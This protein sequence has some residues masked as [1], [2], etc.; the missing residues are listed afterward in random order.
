MCLCK[1][2]FYM[3]YF[4]EIWNLN[5]LTTPRDCHAVALNFDIG[6]CH[7]RLPNYQIAFKNTCA[8][9]YHKVVGKV[10]LYRLYFAS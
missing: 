2:T 4:R 8:C 5:C 6:Y 9:K 1:H 7:V 3:A 10:I